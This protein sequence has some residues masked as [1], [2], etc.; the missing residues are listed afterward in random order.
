M[1]G[2]R[3]RHRIRLFQR[4][5]RGRV[6]VRV[7]VRVLEQRHSIISISF[8][9][10]EVEVGRRRQHSCAGRHSLRLNQAVAVTAFW[11]SSLRGKGVT[12][13]RPKRKPTHDRRRS[14]QRTAT[15]G[16]LASP[17]SKACAMR[18]PTSSEHACP[19]SGL[20]CGRLLA[21]AAVRWQERNMMRVGYLHSITPSLERRV[22]ADALNSRAQPSHLWADLDKVSTE[23]SSEYPNLISV[24]YP[25]V[26]WSSGRSR[27]GISPPWERSHDSRPHPPTMLFVGSVTHGDVLVRALVAL[28]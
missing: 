18:S 16:F 3:A 17:P 23:R 7:R 26:H 20:L 8:R 15:V 5:H 2:R 6:R 28:L 11:R 4:A 14:R 24:P 25:S 1:P 19:T 22:R 13:R 12:K 9:P 21:A 27:A 10:A